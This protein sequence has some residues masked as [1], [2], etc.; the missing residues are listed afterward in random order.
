M[1]GSGSPGPEL[2]NTGLE[3]LFDAYMCE[4]KEKKITAAKKELP[5]ITQG[6]KTWERPVGL[7]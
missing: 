1:Q 7:L 6:R 3:G 4:R 5:F 2:R